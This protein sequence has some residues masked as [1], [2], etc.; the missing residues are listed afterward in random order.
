MAE[1]F[2]IFIH[3]QKNYRKASLCPR[4]R[5]ERALGRRIQKPPMLFA[6]GRDG[7]RWLEV[8]GSEEE[9]GY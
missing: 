8:V 1:F 7:T 6:T 2:N 9:L 4:E 5:A 3:S